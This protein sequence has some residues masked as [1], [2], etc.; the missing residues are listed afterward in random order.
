MLVAALLASAFAAQTG[1][2][3]RLIDVRDSGRIVRVG[4]FRPRQYLGNRRFRGGV[5]PTRASAIKA[6][7]EPDAVNAAGCMNKWLKLRIRI[8]TS[9]FGG[10]DACGSEGGVQHVEIL[11]RAWRTER[12][13]RVGDSLSRVRKLYPK[14]ERFTKVFG[15]APAYRDNWLLV[16]EPSSVGGPP[17][18][19]DRLSAVIR[20]SRVVLLR[21]SPYGAGD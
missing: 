4:A 19:L 10:G 8:V 6:Y 17:N 3:S 15:D 2:T 16:F 13:L 1:D 20:R 11:S 21:V 14:T 5:A 7:G 18:K 12:G 9:D